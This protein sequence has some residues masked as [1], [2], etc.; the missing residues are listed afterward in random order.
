MRVDGPI[1]GTC[2]VATSRW[3][4][5]AAIARHGC[6]TADPLPNGLDALR[7]LA[8]AIVRHV[9]AGRGAAGAAV[10]RGRSLAIRSRPASRAPT[11]RRVGPAVRRGTLSEDPW[12]ESFETHLAGLACRRV[13]ALAVKES[14]RE[15]DH[16]STDA[17]RSARVCVR[18][19]IDAGAS[20]GEP[21]EHGAAISAARARHRARLV[22]DPCRDHR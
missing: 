12:P 17:L 5:H 9:R 13:H 7:L 2:A 15:W 8:S 11:S 10:S 21:R 20:P 14:H 1:E 6:A 18:A 16:N 3:G 19:A 22:A 4:P